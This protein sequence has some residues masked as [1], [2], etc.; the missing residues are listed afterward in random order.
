MVFQV[1]FFFVGGWDF[2]QREYR[3]YYRGGKYWRRF[4]EG[5][6]SV[7]GVRRGDAYISRG[8]LIRDEGRSKCKH[9]TKLST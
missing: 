9:T 3:N 7:C 8:P 5:V 1:W 6:G 4:G 2:G